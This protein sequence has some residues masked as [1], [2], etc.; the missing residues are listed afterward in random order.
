M[1]F[2]QWHYPFENKETFERVFPADFISE[3][4]DQ[5]RGWFYTLLAVN[6]VLFDKAPF[7]NCIVLGHVNDKDGVKMS[8]HKGNVVDPWTVLDKQGADATRWYFYTTSAPWLPSRF[9]ADAVSETQ[10]KFMG[11]LWNTYAFF[12][13]YAEIDKFNPLEHNLKDQKLTIMDKWILSGL[14]TLIKSVDEGLAEYKIT[15]TS[16]AIGDFVDVLSNWYV[17]RS[18]ERFWG[19][20]MTKNKEA[21][22]TT[23]YTVLA[24]LSKIL[25]PFTPFLAEEMYQNLVRNFDENA[26]E[27]VHLCSFPTADESMIDPR[28]EEGMGNVLKLVVLGRAARNG[29]NLKNRQPLSRLFYNG[30]YELSND[31]KELVEDELNVKSVEHSQDSNVFVSYD[32]KPQLR[33]LGPKYGSLLGKIRQLLQERAEEIVAAVKSGN[34]FKYDIDGKLVELAKD[35]LL[36]NM[37]NKEGFSSESDGETTVVLD[38]ELTPE[39]IDEGIE[40]EIV[41]KIQN[42]RKEAGFEV[43]DHIVV[44]YKATGDAKKIFDRADFLKDVLADS[45]STTIDG[46]AKDCD[47][48]GETVTI[49]VKRV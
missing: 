1:P 14:N 42:M 22:Y 34:L 10:R 47:I 41:S 5:T 9:H 27:S 4:V 6:T 15:E 46:F 18:R 2:A 36:I 49:S 8:K 44:G 3:A 25:A 39:L 19:S 31:L 30:R 13:L 43:T 29:S 12:V 21:A 23:L 7:K 48:N 28:L 35:D 20:D 11:T 17:R 16:R 38:T 26:P 33:T 24:T 45:I 32:L 37:K 40:R